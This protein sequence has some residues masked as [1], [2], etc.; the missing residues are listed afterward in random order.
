M[1]RCNFIQDKTL[2]TEREKVFSFHH[3]WLYHAHFQ[4]VTVTECQIESLDYDLITHDV[5]QLC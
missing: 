4:P 3:E 5:L 2:W 1:F